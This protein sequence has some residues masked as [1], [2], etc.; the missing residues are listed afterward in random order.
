MRLSI[1]HSPDPDDAFMVYALAKDLIDV[2]FD[3]ELVS[4]PIDRLN[5]QALNRSWDVT[6]LS[7]HAYGH[8]HE[9]YRLLPVGS[10]V[11][12]D[13]GPVVVAGEELDLSELADARIGVPGRWTTAYLVSRL[14]LPPF[15]PVEVPFDEVPDAL[16]EGAIDAGV[17]VHEGQITYERHGLVELLDLGR[18]WRQETDLPLPLGLN[19]VTRSLPESVQSGAGRVFQA[20]VEYAMEHRE[21]ALDYAMAHG[22]GLGRE[23]VDRYVKMYVNEDTLALRDDVVEALEVLYDRAAEDGMLEAP[24]EIDP[25]TVE[26]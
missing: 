15:Q 18:W 6:A 16:A 17:L 11:G 12:R 22:P 4:E 14:A 25:V 23:D 5:E 7:A 9:V 13:Y 2:G 1:A 24:A 19:A 21:N 3:V 26:A 10:S 8:L 20:S